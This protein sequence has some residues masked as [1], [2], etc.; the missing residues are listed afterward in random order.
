[1]KLIYENIEDA[2]TIVDLLQR[3]R[4]ECKDRAHLVMFDKPVR[5]WYKKRAKYIQE[6]LDDLEL[7]KKLRPSTQIGIAEDLKNP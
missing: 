4:E 7:V 1:M 3:E 6:I 5:S 2:D